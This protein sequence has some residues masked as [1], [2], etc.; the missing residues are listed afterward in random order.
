MTPTSLKILVIASEYFIALDIQRA[1]AELPDA[2]VDIGQSHTL[3]AEQLA[4][5]FDVVV[6]EIPQ[7]AATT[8]S[9]VDTIESEGSALI[10]ISAYSVAAN[11]AAAAKAWPVVDI[12]FV[13]EALHRA[14][15]QALAERKVPR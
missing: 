9:Y 7:D 13:D 3:F 14:V 4:P 12:P 11:V 10:F 8:T 1:L 2:Q 6:A 5:G 15:A